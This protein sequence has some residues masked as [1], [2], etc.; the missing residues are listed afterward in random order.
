VDTTLPF[1]E[2]RRRSLINEAAQAAD[3]SSDFSE[4]RRPWADMASAKVGFTEPN[5]DS[6][7]AACL[8]VALILPEGHKAVPCANARARRRRMLSDH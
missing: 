2:L 4:C 3:G 6:R 5:H 7:K 1:E 8:S